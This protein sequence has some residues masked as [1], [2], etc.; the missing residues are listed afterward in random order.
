MQR[1][2][3]ML[4][5]NPWLDYR[6][7][8]K[9][10][11]ITT[12]KQMGVLTA[13]ADGGLQGESLDTANV[14]KHD[15]PELGSCLIWYEKKAV[16]TNGK[17]LM[18]R[19]GRPI[20]RVQGLILRDLSG[21]PE[22]LNP[23][24][25]DALRTMRT[26]AD[27]AFA[28]FES[29]R[30]PPPSPVIAKALISPEQPPPVGVGGLPPTSGA[31]AQGRPGGRRDPHPPEQPPP[32]PPKVDRRVIVAALAA[33]G[34][35]SLYAFV[36]SFSHNARLSDTENRVAL[37]EDRISKTEGRMTNDESEVGAFKS[38]VEQTSRSEQEELERLKGVIVALQTA[39]QQLK[40]GLQEC[41]AR[42]D[43]ISPPLPPV[44]E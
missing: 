44:K 8:L 24:D 17:D 10:E 28:R 32:V 36:S 23:A 4:A 11:F 15:S 30:P 33:L 1:W 35:L 41:R 13:I 20:Y 9:P 37:T 2:P 14:V 34:A 42:I 22:G 43:A 5:A 16:R 38:S 18:D 6:I 31:S 39:N 40:A 19:A 25:D 7:V 21:A 3:F 26:M 27:E 29:A 12:P